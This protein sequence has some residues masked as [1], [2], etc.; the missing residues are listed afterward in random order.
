MV[1]QDLNPFRFETMNHQHQDQSHE[2]LNQHFSPLD[3]P[4]THSNTSH[5]NVDFNNNNVQCLMTKKCEQ[6]TSKLTVIETKSDLDLIQESYVETKEFEETSKLIESN[7]IERTLT[8]LDTNQV[9][10]NFDSVSNADEDNYD[11]NLVF[12]DDVLD[13]IEMIVD[14]YILLEKTRWLLHGVLW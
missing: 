9:D 8:L 7:Q 1:D 12:P 6:L 5:L 2:P 13:D 14:L 11:D 10:L 4:L 3:V